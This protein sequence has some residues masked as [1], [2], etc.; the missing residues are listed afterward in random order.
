[1]YGVIIIAFADGSLM[2]ITGGVVSGI[3]TCTTFEMEVP[4]AL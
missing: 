3:C 4:I 2:V 1:M